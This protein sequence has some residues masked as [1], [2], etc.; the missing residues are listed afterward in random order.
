MFARF[1]LYPQY[2]LINF[3][4]SDDNSSSQYLVK[5]NVCRTLFEP[6]SDMF[7]FGEVSFLP[8]VIRVSR[9]WFWSSRA[10]RKSYE[11]LDFK[12]NEWMRVNSK[13]WV[14][15]NDA[16]YVFLIRGRS[17]V[18]RDFLLDWSWKEYFSFRI[19]CHKQDCIF[20][21]CYMINSSYDSY[22]GEGKVE[23]IS[24]FKYVRYPNENCLYCC[25]AIAS[26]SPTVSSTE[27]SI[28]WLPE[29]QRRRMSTS[30]RWNRCIIEVRCRG[31]VMIWSR[32][33]DF[34]WERGYLTYLK[35]LITSTFPSPS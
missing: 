2:E 13:S 31:F 33:V 14:I 6:N 35:S 7:L 30:L 26:H 18:V 28:W 20:P 11:Y 23:V 24:D 22:D 15:T 3:E 1:L 32:L 16:Q 8:L 5:R 27:R 9:I 17:K 29:D 12:S 10:M 4:N 21:W 25:F 19:V 34:V